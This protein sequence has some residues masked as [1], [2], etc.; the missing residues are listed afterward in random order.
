MLAGADLLAADLDVL[1]RRPAELDD[2][3]RPAHD[4]LDGRVDQIGVT[5]ELLELGGV[6]DQGQQ[7][8]A[9]GVARRLVAGHDEYQEVGEHLERR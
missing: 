3:R 4:L 7:T 9:R 1:D 6:L 5:L 8:P 2:G